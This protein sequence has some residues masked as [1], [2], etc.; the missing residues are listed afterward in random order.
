MAFRRN[1]R[2]LWQ[3]GDSEYRRIHGG[4]A[5]M[6][7]EGLGGIARL[8]YALHQSDY[9]FFSLGGSCGTLSCFA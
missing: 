3:T 7:L 6:G 5:Y 1:L 4:A 9:I 8:I 2:R